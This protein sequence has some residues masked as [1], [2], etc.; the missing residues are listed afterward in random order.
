MGLLSA[1]APTTGFLARFESLRAEAEAMG[2]R[3][4][5]FDGDEPVVEP[6][7]SPEGA[8]KALHIPKSEIDAWLRRPVS[9]LPHLMPSKQRRVRLTAVAEY[10]RRQELK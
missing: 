8:A 2:L 7:Y 3:I 10:A 4:V 6:Y 5:A 1:E 9:P